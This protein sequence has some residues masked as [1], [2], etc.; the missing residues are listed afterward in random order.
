M[1][2]K[3]CLL[4]GIVAVCSSLAFTQGVITTAAGG[5]WIF[6]GDGQPAVSAP[7]GSLQGV[8]VDANG[9]VYA[10]DVGNDIV[11]RITPDGILTVVAGNGIAGYSGDGGP[12]T[13]A[14]L[15][16]FNAGNIALDAAGNLYIADKEGARV[17]KVNSGGI[18]TTVAGNSIQGYS[19]DGGPATRA[20]LRGPN[21]LAV[22]RAGN[23][24]IVDSDNHR[25]R[26]VTPGGIIT[27][28]AGNGT[29]ALAGDGG[30]ATA[31]S[32]RFPIGLALD[33]AGNLYVA[34][35][36]N[37]RVRKIGTDGTINT[38][39]GSTSGFGGDGGPAT[40][41]KLTLPRGVAV[42]GLGNAYIADS[43]NHRIRRVSS[44]GIITTVAGTGTPDFSGDGGPALL[45]TLYQ[46]F[47]V[48]VD[49][50]GNFYIADT[51][52]Y[53]VRKVSA[54]GTISTIAGNQFYKYGGDGG[55]ATAASLNSPLGL[56]AD[57]AG[58]L[59]I[60]DTQNH[61]VRKVSRA[62]IM[63]T[64]AGTGAPGYSGDGVAA[65]TAK[66]KS[67]KGVALDAAG[68]LYICDSDNHRIRKVGAN[69]FISTLAGNG[70][71]GYSGDGVAATRSSLAWPNGIALDATGNLYIADF[72][73]G[74]V[75]MVA[76]AGTITTVAGNGTAGFSGD[77]GQATAAS[78]TNPSGVAV[79][80]AGNVYI[81]AD[82]RVR[83][84]GRDGAIT[85]VA[86][87]GTAAFSGDGGPAAAASL[88]NPVAVAIDG[89]GNL[90]IG[91][92]NR[93]RKVGQNGVINT[94]AG[95]G[96]SRMT[97]D[98]GPAVAASNNGVGGLTV[99]PAGNLFFSDYGNDRVR[100]VLAGPP[101][102]LVTPAK[103]SLSTPAGS[104]LVAPQQI[105]VGGPVLG[106]VWG[107]QVS[108]EAGGA[109]LSVSP[110][111]GAVPATLDVSLDAR[112]LTPGA[113]RGTVT[114]IAPLAS[115]ASQTAVVELTVSAT[116]PPSL[117]VEPASLS[118]EAATT[119]GNPPAQVLRV[120]N[121]GGGTLDWS[122][123]AATSNGG[124]WL[125][126][127]PASGSAASGSPA[128]LSVSVSI[129][130]LTA[131]VYSG[132]LILLSN[133]TGQTRTVSV[134]LLLSESAQAILLSQAG[135]AFTGVEGGSV[136]PSQSFGV[137]NTG[138]GVMSWSA[139]ATTLSGGNWLSVKPASGRTDATSTEVPMVDVLVDTTGL[140]AGRYSGLIRTSAPGARNSPQML[141]VELEVLPA[142]ANPGALVRPTGLVFA[143]QTGTSSPGSQTVRIATA[144]LSGVSMA[145]GLL[146]LDGAG[147]L[148][149]LPRSQTIAPAAPGTITVQPSLST[150]APGVYRG[151]VTLLFS[152]GSTQ[153]ATIL[154][155]VTASP[156]A[157]AASAI[158]A[159]GV[160][161]PVDAACAA[162]R[163]LLVWR[164]T[165]N[166]FSSPA[167]W[168]SPI[169]VQ[170]TDDCGTPVPNASVVVTFSNG[171][172]P[173]MLTSL[174]NGTYTGTWR[175]LGESAQVIVTARASLPPLAA[176]EVKAQGQVL[177]NTRSPAVF[178]GGVVSAASYGG[179][180]LAPGALVS[181]FGRKLAAATG[182]A[183]SLPL[184][185]TLNGSVLSVGGIDSPLIFASDGQIN[186]Q[187]PAELPPNSR[188][189]VIVRLR[190]AGA[191]EILSVPETVTLAAV[192]P[193]IFTTNQQGTG[194]GAIRDEQ[195]RLVDASAPVAAGSV[196]QVYCTGLGATS[197][198]VA[199]GQ[200]A[201][202][203]EPLARV[204]APVEARIGGQTAPVLFAGL[205]PGFAGLHQVN[206]QIPPGVTPGPAVELVLW[207][208]GVPSNTVTLAIR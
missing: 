133:A 22:D 58:S 207:Q 18:I 67:P 27:T 2:R 61:R 82:N 84:V 108:T 83:Q 36:A 78:L 86:G 163:L 208:S 154:F 6:R 81:A 80:L 173:L 204:V 145:A 55:P 101:S 28:F 128:Q 196:V 167:A 194:Q 4:M 169:E 65:T 143:A 97:G 188:T 33:A 53:R 165:G 160:L 41:A 181:V 23:L 66:L 104:L 20:S 119:T 8:A 110:A 26:K 141:T 37:H 172:P 155:L 60:A 183:S 182:G 175:P 202:A 184:P 48:A 49:A 142:G 195:D 62:G 46:P 11:V 74:R 63:T 3:L 205:A 164:S 168:P 19:G 71:A 191:S 76:P 14:S 156:G 126:V 121:A 87:N 122:A 94:V 10:A 189:Q 47:A 95:D 150:L 136:V 120:S 106:L 193:A 161:R 100:Q 178:S 50:S 89:S 38:L 131:G 91:D 118:F 5:S 79:D 185:T 43:D 30:P 124:R 52:N 200:A 17:R 162:Q 68:N 179:A 51:V 56:A 127:S 25:I 201:P 176:A 59:Y 180:A 198:A 132:S 157:G 93:V 57:S 13:G 98:G 7:L 177:S 21:G 39:A 69:G 77:G 16:F 152:D 31:A 72:G 166:G 105:A 29:G 15:F 199:S 140:R 73:N 107:A 75:R 206:V 134:S 192:Q 138:Q 116:T 111:S 112:A 54:L 129:S 174:R 1:Y 40:A 115:P 113:Y 187:L 149:A 24:Y 42:D 151:A 102:F 45:A 88:R 103:L 147:W 190:K 144:A 96:Y 148:E 197:P 32:L 92:G 64:V 90:L 85:T 135:L 109:W 170:V 146:T 159:Q 70:S 44:T 158:Q 9:Y 186:A 34:D 114:V 12:A 35:S 203:V 137:L 153:V 125:S 130:G 99:D 117:I 171:D 123:Q 139:S